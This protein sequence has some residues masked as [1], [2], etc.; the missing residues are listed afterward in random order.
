LEIQRISDQELMAT[1]FRLRVAAWA[2][3]G[4]TL[5]EG[6]GG[7]FRD[8]VDESAEHYGVVAGKC[9]VGAIR[10][11]HHDSPDTLG[12]PAVSGYAP[13]EPPIALLGRLV[14]HPNLQRL[15]IGASLAHH[16]ARQAMSGSARTLVAYVNV[17]VI[18]DVVNSHGFCTVG[19]IDLPW[20]NQTLDAQVVILKR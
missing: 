16:A 14:V 9:V 15:G 7:G 1:I 5:P 3:A 18:A 19:R 13:L 10:V 17:R 4:V 8:A 6:I 20:G 2:N 12:M 11:S